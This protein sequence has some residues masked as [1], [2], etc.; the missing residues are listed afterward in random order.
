M[1]TLLPETEPLIELVTTVTPAIGSKTTVPEIDEPVC[2][3]ITIP[4]DS[5]GSS[6]E[7]SVHDPVTL[8]VG[9]VVGDGAG[10]GVGAGSGVGVGAGVGVVGTGAGA[11]GGGVV[12]VGVGV[13][14]VLVLP[15]HAIITV[16]ATIDTKRIVITVSPGTHSR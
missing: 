9:G 3:K 1:V 10:V 15:P 7:G 11:A 16:Q 4:S 2:V 8:I 6:L 13:V 5:P 14:G 12:A